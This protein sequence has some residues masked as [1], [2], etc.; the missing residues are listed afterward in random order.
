MTKRHFRLSENQL[1]EDFEKAKAL[2]LKWNHPIMLIERM[3]G[4][5]GKKD[6]T[7]GGVRRGGGGGGG[8]KGGVGAGE[9]SVL[10]W[11]EEEE[12]DALEE[13]SEWVSERV[14]SEEDPF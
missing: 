5:K 10:R 3:V 13:R 2:P 12:E 6:K 14:I 8:G 1:Y 9:R 4:V 7:F 11:E